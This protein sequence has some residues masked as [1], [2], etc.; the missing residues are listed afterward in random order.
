MVMDFMQGS[1]S[2]GQ[3]NEALTKMFQ[4]KMLAEM[5]GIDANQDPVAMEAH[6]AGQ[7]ANGSFGVLGLRLMP[8][9][10]TQPFPRLLLETNGQLTIKPEHLKGLIQFLQRVQ[11]LLE[12][13]YANQ[14]EKAKEMEGYELFAGMMGMTE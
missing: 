13:E 7:D 2:S 11:P 6:V 3:G 8:P 12:T 10:P 5:F 9:T 14:S 4:Q 1:G